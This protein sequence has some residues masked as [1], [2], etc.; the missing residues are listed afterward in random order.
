MTGAGVGWFEAGSEG[1]G[2][3][4]RA[5][6]LEQGLDGVEVLLELGVDA[7]GGGGGPELGLERRERASG[8][9]FGHFGVWRCE[10]RAVCAWRVWGC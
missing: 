1:G 6:G 5:S 2:G 4:A 10:A 9:V 7:V 3:A 8:V